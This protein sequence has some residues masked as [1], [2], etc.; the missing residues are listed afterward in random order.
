M[1]YSL[2][3]IRRENACSSWGFSTKIWL[4]KLQK[5]VCWEGM[6][7]ITKTWGERLVYVEANLCSS[8]PAV[9]P[10]HTG[11]L[12]W[13]SWA[14]TY[15]AFLQPSSIVWIVSSHSLSWQAVLLFLPS[16]LQHDFSYEWDPSITG[17]IN[18]VFRK[19]LV[20][21][22]E[23]ISREVKGFDMGCWKVDGE[24]DK[25]WVCSRLCGWRRVFCS[26]VCCKL[27]S[28]NTL[29]RR[30]NCQMGITELHILQMMP[31]MSLSERQVNAR[32]RQIHNKDHLFACLNSFSAGSLQITPLRGLPD[33]E[34]LESCSQNK[35][36]PLY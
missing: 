26:V 35:I 33:P 13:V 5:T 24:A 3:W 27:T 21:L 19:S 17:C 20:C 8:Q 11:V 6:C 4:V 36:K 1:S 16:L 32:C 34:V 25:L 14:G 10:P 15:L 22:F 23:S 29:F 9:L 12:S 30:A 18:S 2:L 7:V 28:W 31:L